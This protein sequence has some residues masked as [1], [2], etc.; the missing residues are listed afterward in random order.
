MAGGHQ[1]RDEILRGPSGAVVVYNVERHQ[2][3]K[4][5]A[6]GHGTWDCCREHEPQIRLLPGPSP[7]GVED[8]PETEEELMDQIHDRVAGLDVHRDT[9]T[10]CV[11]VPGPRRG[12]IT[13]K[14]RFDTTTA[15]LTRMCEW[16]RTAGVSLVALEATGVYWKPVYYALEN[17]F[18]VWLCNAH[19]VKNV[20]GRKTDMS[21]AEW[22]A[23]VAAHGMVRA[24]F[25]PP[26][27]IR[28]LRELTRYRKTQIDA[29]ASEIQRLEKV[30]QDAGIKLTSVASKVLTQSGRAM[31]DALIEGE[32]DPAC[33]AELAKGKL[34]PKIPQLTEALTGHFGAHHAVAAS[35]ILAHIDF[36]D[37]TIDALSEQIRNRTK[38][39]QAVIDLLLPVPGLDL[40]SIEV[41]IAETGADMTRFS[42]PAQLASWAGLCPGNHESAGRRRRAGTPHGNQWLRRTLVETARAA[43]RTKDSYFAAQYWQITRRRGPNKAAIAVAHS[44]LDTIWHLLSTGEV[45]EDLGADYFERRRD[46]QR[47][48]RRLVDRLES[49]GYTVTLTAAS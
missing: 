24:S 22:L 9:V 13:S 30:L 8:Q 33:L 7:A 25:V 32:R 14:E 17:T 40:C 19:H 44:L 12:T 31:V 15:G 35:R 45:Y 38:P 49:L 36:L 5:L 39:F 11:R 41:I 23:D 28:E 21:D 27:P 26:L 1:G 18:E 20:P 10:A 34:R 43:A 4:S 3:V 16:L 6:L 48:A 2:P 42:S 47:Q 29:R 37:A 46:P